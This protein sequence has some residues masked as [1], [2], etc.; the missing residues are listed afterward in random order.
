[1]NSRSVFRT[2]L[3]LCMCNLWWVSLAQA[4]KPTAKE[5]QAV[6][7]MKTKI[8]QAGK[9]YK[10]KK[11]DQCRE[12]IE[13]AIP[14]FMTATQGARQELLELV[15]PE[16]DRLQKAHELLLAAGEELS[17]LP[18]FPQPVS[19]DSAVVSFKTLVAPILVAKCGN[20]HI[21]RKQGNFS[22]A[23]FE[24]LDQSTML[25]FG[26]PQDSRLI[27]VIESGEMPK[28]GLTVEPAELQILKDWITQGAKFD[29][30]NPRQNLREIVTSTAAPAATVA[31][32]TPA[33]P[34]G[35]ETVSFGL[36]IAPILVEHCGQCHMN[37]NPSGNFNQASFETLLRGGDSGPPIVPYKTEASMLYKR[38]VAGEMPPTGKLDA[39]LIELFG[40]WITEGAK[41]DG[42]DPKL[43]TATV[44]TVAKAKSQSHAELMADRKGLSAKN[45]NLVMGQTESFTLQSDN[46]LVIGSADK[47]RLDEISTQLTK[48]APKVAATLKSDSAAPLVKGNISVFVFEKR[49][50]FSEFG[51]MV[52][53]RDFSKDVSAYWNYTVSDAYATI[54]LPPNQTAADAEISLVQQMAALHVASLAPDVP[55]WFADGVGYWTAKKILAQQEA[56][57]AWDAESVAAAGT[58]KQPDDFINNR[59]PAEQAGLV[60]YLFVKSLK[61][62][63]GSFDD[64]LDSMRDGKS[65]ERSFTTAFGTTAAEMLKRVYKNGG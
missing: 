19:G 65:F 40:T 37:A 36:Q 38:L 48:A 16:Y 60:S 5:K 28:G 34:T 2:V 10:S 3:L 41:Y 30:D 15:K 50:D 21:N 46:F 4:Q 63:G 23:T 29:G 59:M 62:K 49:Y 8:D 17:T 52:E 11:M 24:S 14:Q 55:R 57:K 33:A 53:R 43:A 1:M 7:L 9:F 51:K 13:A 54:L 45:W 20:C 42:V 58:M 64:L 56:V 35:K 18:P 22:T 61:S 44:A 32:P 27:E 47:K 39:K 26:L 31:A 12:A 25:A 6:R